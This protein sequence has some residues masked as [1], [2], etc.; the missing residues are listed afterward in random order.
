MEPTHWAPVICRRP[1]CGGIVSAA[2]VRRHALY[3]SD[4]CSTQHYN[5]RNYHSVGKLDIPTGTIGA[6]SELVIS[7]DLLRRGFAVFRAVSPSCSCDLAVLKDGKLF[8]VEVTTGYV[9]AGKLSHSKK[10]D[11]GKW[12]LL[13]IV[14]R[15]GRITYEP[16]FND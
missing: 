6:I 11:K 7:A 15:Q 1:A 13:G 12:D 10:K 8:R 2:K 3:C 16:P 4:R 5:D 9:V 14:D